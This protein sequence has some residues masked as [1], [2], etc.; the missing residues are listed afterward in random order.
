[1]ERTP[2]FVDN[3]PLRP[4]GEI[5]KRKGLKTARVAMRRLGYLMWRGIDVASARLA[6]LVNAADLKS[7]GL[8]PWRF[9]SSA[10]HLCWTG[11]EP[12]PDLAR[13]ATAVRGIAPFSNRVATSS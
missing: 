5:G 12:G 8:C 10:E 13:L 4:G 2:G 6:K 1:M 7:A 9:D 11:D 3:F